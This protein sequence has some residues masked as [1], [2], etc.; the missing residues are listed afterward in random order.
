M[1]RINPGPVLADQRAR[2]LAANTPAGRRSFGSFKLTIEQRLDAVQK[3]IANMTFGGVPE[4]L[5]KITADL[6][7]GL[8]DFGI[9]PAE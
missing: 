6:K 5:E 1:S 8:E 3:K 9:V 4:E 2:N 7:Q